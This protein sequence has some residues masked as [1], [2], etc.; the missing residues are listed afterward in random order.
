M[1][2][3]VHKVYLAL[4]LAGFML[5]TLA[6]GSAA[7]PD[8]I[9]PMT[10]EIQS[11]PT[12]SPLSQPELKTMGLPTEIPTPKPSPTTPPELAP[13]RLPNEISEP[14]SP[15]APPATAT[16]PGQASQ[17]APIIPGS[18]AAVAAAIATLA[19]QSGLPANQITVDSV[20]A[21][22]WPDTSL[23][24]PQEGMMYAQVITPG[25]LIMLSVQGQMYEYHTDQK[26]N[27]VPC[28]K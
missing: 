25:Y 7:T 3:V 14:S 8:D 6:C 1:R 24:C 22:E 4:L 9:P 20:T 23:G 2:C 10:I 27:V 13:T 18:E 28:K 5:A 12:T 17:P 19:K 11:V 16:P 26:A 15:L 21:M